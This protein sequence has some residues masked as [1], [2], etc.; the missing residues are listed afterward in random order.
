MP[1]S[2]KEKQGRKCACGAVFTTPRS[3]GRHATSCIFNQQRN[4]SLQL[5][6]A[7]PPSFTRTDHHA[8]PTNTSVPPQ[9]GGGG[10]SLR[11]QRNFIITQKPALEERQAQ[12]RQEQ[13]ALQ[14]ASHLNS[15]NKPT[16]SNPTNDNQKVMGTVGQAI[17]AT[18]SQ[19][20]DN[21][22]NLEEDANNAPS[23][24]SYGIE[25]AN[26][27]Q[28]EAED[29]KS[30]IETAD[31]SSDSSPTL[32]EPVFPIHC[33]NQSKHGIKFSGNVSHSTAAGLQLMQVLGRH[34][35]DLSLYD[36]IVRVI[37]DIANDGYDFK[38]RLPS[39]HTLHTTCEK[40]FNY[41]TL[42]PKF[43]EVPVAT[44]TVPTVKVPVFDIQAVLS[45]ML[46]NPMLM[47][48][49]NFAADYDIYSGTSTRVSTENGDTVEVGD[50]AYYDEIHTGQRWKP[51]VAH[52]CAGD[53]NLFP[54]G[55]VVFYDKSHSDR[56][57]S[58]SVSP[59]MFTL[60]LFN[61]TARS[62]SE[63]WD[64][65][66][67]IPN[68]DYGTTKSS[69]SSIQQNVTP[70][71]KCQDEHN[72]LY[73]A[74]RQLQDVNERGGI[75][76]RV[77]GR[78][79][80]VKVWIH[81]VIG[82][83]AGNNS[84]LGSY[85]NA[86][87]QCPYRDCSC[88]RVSFVDP[89]STCNMIL[90]SGIDQMKQD[91]NVDALK[92]ASK[93][94]I[95][96]A[97]DK[98][99]TG[100]PINTI[101]RSTPPETM[102]AICSGIVPRMLTAFGDGFKKKQA[103]SVL[104]NLHLL[105]AKQHAW[106]SE[107]DFPRPSVRNFVLETTKTQA[108]EHMGNLFL[109]LCALHTTMGK[110]ICETSGITNY[111]RMGKITTIKMILSLEKWFNRRNLRSDIDNST[112][113]DEFVRQKLIPNLQKIFPRDEGMEWKFPKV[114]SLTKFVTFIQAFGSAIN[115]YGGFGESHLKVFMKHYAHY[116]QRRPGK[117]AEQLATNHYRHGLFEHS[118]NCIR[119]QT[120][121]NY[122]L[123]QTE[124]MDE[125]FTGK[126]TITFTRQQKNT[127]NANSVHYSTSVV[128]QK[129]SSSKSVDD[130]LQYAI[131]HHMAAY[132]N[133][134]TFRVTAYTV[135]KL[136]NNKETLEDYDANSSHS[137][138]R[139]D[140]KTDRN[141]WC[142]ILTHALG[143][144]TDDETLN[145]WDYVC[146]GRIHGFFRFETPGL[147]TPQLL[148]A[149]NA[150]TINSQ[151]LMDDTTYVV[152]RTPQKFLDWTNLE[153]EFIVPIQLGDLDSCT[154]ILPVSRIVNPLYV[155]EDHGQPLKGSS[156]FAS[157]PARYWA[158]YLD[159]KLKPDS[160]PGS[161]GFSQKV[162][163]YNK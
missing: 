59:L 13:H 7:R 53:N 109:L 90:K 80:K 1:P 104:H 99:P 81:I 142:M 27:Y 65:L 22:M 151:R 115:F 87:A 126:H 51:A 17:N 128:W 131:S 102:H 108:T 141:D 155:F 132:V 8:P 118:F 160:A 5:H 129:A 98:I 152:V 162:E 121:M 103:A 82:D 143:S 11:Q 85:N 125:T 78:D 94:N 116:T 120:K 130:T 156:F 37:G 100:D 25:F 122:D 148:Q 45:K 35:T 28:A 68:L 107:R 113:I 36:D 18:N 101:Y 47:Q 57:G 38:H 72:C 34:T 32:E 83:I 44:M 58:L 95:V 30:M 163:E 154:F 158:F 15:M 41:A 16:N 40:H 77:K 70:A 9:H 145:V 52:Y 26:D 49:E 105:L 161:C 6:H 149:Q 29:N 146:P 69:D 135:A 64:I 4:S 19:T 136:P 66:A 50:I 96:N 60:T 71:L 63:F 97:F 112:R 73:T 61:K 14:Y 46:C 139:V 111:E 75:P 55:L 123:M 114:H 133:Y 119:E 21:D 56:N 42:Q 106:Q 147:P 2:K 33:D 3:F 31:N 54:C 88:S 138:Y 110:S 92:A 127:S 20:H 39:R 157:I 89:S 91:N 140:T 117:F 150:D 67:Y 144:D 10:M 137:I 76:M 24:T 74:L 79:V 43:V 23:D 62:K 84:L 86:F 124:C 153:K 159:Y 134:S 12:Q 48:T 93:H